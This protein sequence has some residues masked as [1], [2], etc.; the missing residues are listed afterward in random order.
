M[1][2]QQEIVDRL[3]Q[4]TLQYNLTW[5]DVK[6]DADKAISKINNFMGT[7][8]PK[9]STH[10][11]SP[12]STYTVNVS[13][14]LHEIFPEEYIH[15]VVIP[16]IAMEVL[17]RDEEFTTIYN[18]Y[19]KEYE[20]GLF[21]MF[22]KEFNR[23]PHVFRQNPDQG[24]FFTPTTMNAYSN[25]NDN[26]S[27][28]TF[29][30]RVHYHIN[31]DNIV[32]STGNGDVLKFV[33]DTHAYAYGETALIMDWDTDILS[34]TGATAYVFQGWAYGKN[35]VT[36]SII[37]K[38]SNTSL[39]VISDIHLYAMWET[40]STLYVNTEYSNAVYIKE[41]YKASLTNLEIP[42]RVGAH[43]VNTIP[44]GFC[45]EAT[46]LTS[47]T[48][49]RYLRLIFTQAFDGFKGHSITFADSDTF[50]FIG[51][52]AFANTPYLTNIVIPT[53]VVN[54]DEEAFPSDQPKHMNI[55]CRI[56]EIYKPFDW[57]DGWYAP[58]DISTGYSVNVEWG[59]NG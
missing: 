46:R 32:L 5:Y 4:L 48:L 42:D 35:Q 31:N 59:Y 41:K 13:G 47:I 3:N 20:D 10:L 19:N 36:E 57:V 16:F 43:F 54:I 2:T 34:Y 21:D 8:Y 1:L 49:P 24:V 14:A 40:E 38:G 45:A 50:V 11:V 44:T 51:A 6:Y 18:K 37:S 15:S 28:P 53:N 33:E 56:L 26:T 30:F 58:D 39:T 55:Y 22:Q 12:E 27:I 17:A 25:R 29:K 23:V 52:N 7:T 9:M